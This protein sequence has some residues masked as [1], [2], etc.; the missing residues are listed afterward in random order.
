MD[1]QRTVLWRSLLLTVLIF[2]VGILLNHVFDAVRIDT[3]VGVMR[4]H[5]VHNDAYRVERFF[6]SEFGGE[7]CELLTSRISDFKKEIRK[8]GEDLGSYSRFS[9]FRRNDYDYLKR[10]YFL[11]EF[12]FLALVE[13]V[14]RECDH[15]YVPIVFFYEIDDEDS[16]RQGFILE[17]LS[18]GYDQQLVVLSLDKGYVDEPLVQVLA[19]NYNVTTAPTMVIDGVPYEGL[20]YTGELNLTLRNLLRVADPYGRKFDFMF[21]PRAAGSN[22]SQLVGLL[23]GIIQNESA[24]YFAR[25]DALLVKGRLLKDDSFICQSLSFFDRVNSSSAEERA[26]LFETSASLGCGRNRAAFLRAAASEWKGLNNSFR[27]GLLERLAR[28]GQ[29]QLQ[30]D[31]VATSANTSVIS[32]YFSPIL[33]NLS[34]KGDGLVVGA[35]SVVL[36]SSSVVVSQDDRVFRDWLGG[37]LADP[38]GPEVLTTFSERLS[39]RPSDL[40]REIGWHEGAMVRDLSA[41][42]VQQEV[43]VG[44][45]VARWNDRW[46]AVD[47]AG[48]FRFEVP[49]DKVLYPTTRF[50][51]R[52][53]AVVIDTH[54][55]NMLVEQ[56]V[57]NNASA[58]LGCCD[59]PGKVYAAWYLS[60]RNISTI[61]STDKYLYLALGRNVSAVGSAPIQIVGSE[62]VVGRRPLELS[63]GERVLA[64]NSSDKVFALWYYQ[65][66]ASYVFELAK[67]FPLNVTYFA[68]SN[69]SQM[70]LAM[71]RAR[72]VN[73]SVVAARVFNSADYRA[74]KDWL[75]EHGSRRVLLF[76]SASYPFG[77]KLLD[78]Y[79]ERSSFDDPNPVFV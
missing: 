73:A 71:V 30:F 31:P 13:R 10:K 14:N 53:L 40:L 48:V 42:G 33:P 46:F 78:E 27:A 12:R 7:E 60:Q 5:E 70:E 75:D 3:I 72:E 67:V 45:L 15:P 4:E 28:G 49:L 9:F 69:F 59:H 16:E 35:H 23:D 68:L 63:N 44:T 74:V 52:N 50:L 51:H 24:S 21:T 11:L 17:D 37:Q 56:A 36:N 1:A 76:H 66:P 19:R 39:Y 26:L 8:V 77:R 62:V 34:G 64:V 55:V 18:K 25:G 20:H 6:T 47:D 41:A 38:F 29:L 65:T 57:R 79:P 32:G 58:V 61:C 22:V 2:A 43:A 54:G